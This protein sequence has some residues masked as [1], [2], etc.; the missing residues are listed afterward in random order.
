M[1]YFT[2]TS[3]YANRLI[4]IQTGENN[5][6]TCCGLPFLQQK[7]RRD[8][9][10]DQITKILN[11]YVTRPAGCLYSTND[12]VVQILASIFAGKNDLSDFKKLSRDKG[13]LSSINKI[14]VASSSTVSRYFSKLAECCDIFIERMCR[15]DNIDPRF[16]AKKDTRRLTNELFED[17]NDFILEQ[18]IKI[19]K[20]QGQNEIVFIDVDSTPVAVY[21]NTA[22]G[23]YDGHYRKNCYLPLLVFINN[24][25][26]L[27]QNAP[28][29]TNGAKLL[30]MHLDKLLSRL[31][32]EFPNSKI[33]LRGDTGFSNIDIIDKV[34]YNHCYYILGA[35]HAL[36]KLQDCLFQ[37]LTDFV[38]D[39][40]FEDVDVCV[41]DVIAKALRL[42]NFGI[43]H[44]SLP[45]KEFTSTTRDG[46]VRCCGFVPNYRANSWNHDRTIVYRLEYTPSF[47]EIN[48]RYIQ[49]NLEIEE[50]IAIDEGRG[51]SKKRSRLEDSLERIKTNAEAAINLYEALFCDR[52]QDE[53]LNREWK[54]DCGGKNCSLNSFYANSLRMIFS[55]IAMQQFAQLRHR[56]NVINQNCEILR[57]ARA[58]KKENKSQS[59]LGKK[60]LCGSTI[61][62]I[63]E[64]LIMIAGRIV[65]RKKRV[66]YHIPDFSSDWE[67]AFEL[68]I[69]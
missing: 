52:G 33:I 61:S 16:L 67:K 6:S 37:H 34:N 57:K 21:G 18:C 14:G 32:S 17:L 31:K 59:H 63:R 66:T 20:I 10:Y 8:G 55:T 39:S 13:F 56:I 44:H 40:L 24:I 48:L 41:D 4:S 7:V 46:K 65:E 51:L 12:L 30:L 68:L 11:K 15:E 25:P 42:D 53:R 5:V 54:N 28:G 43:K 49:T 38:E 2:H 50:A 69:L 9:I 64:N 3:D 60:K 47:D 26:A 1:S 62:S 45:R 36:H 19:L 27:V 23:A 22:G 35:N 29:A 58:K